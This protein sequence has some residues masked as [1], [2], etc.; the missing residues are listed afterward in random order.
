MSQKMT[1]LNSLPIHIRKNMDP[2]T[3]TQDVGNDSLEVWGDRSYKVGNKMYGPR[4]DKRGLMA[5]KSK[6][7][8]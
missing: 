5:E 1:S 7:R 3:W 8:Y 2:G 4:S 6:L